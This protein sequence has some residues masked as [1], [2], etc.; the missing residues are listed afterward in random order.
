LS[1]NFLPTA[2][3]VI[4]TVTTVVICIVTCLYVW[5]TRRLLQVTTEA[6]AETSRPYV[7][8]S[9]TS[10]NRK[11]DLV[12]KNFG[13]RAAYNIVVRTEP[14]LSAIALT[15]VGDKMFRPLLRQEVLAPGQEVKG[16]V[17]LT[18]AL[19]RS[20]A[21]RAFDFTITYDDSSGKQF[22]ERYSIDPR[23][24]VWDKSLVRKEWTDHIGGIA[25]S[26][27][28]LITTIDRRIPSA[29]EGEDAL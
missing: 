10:Q 12:I 13:P 22:I 2:L 14:D 11:I 7:F 16:L 21:L 25:A 28:K 26:L 9:L 3:A 1:D 8:A 19:V 17:S 6:H 15:I 18:P 29:S 23:E 24:Y 27:E 5:Y 20:S 4:T